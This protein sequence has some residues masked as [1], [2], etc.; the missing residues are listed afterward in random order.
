MRQ[1]E[2]WQCKECMARLCETCPDYNCA[3]PSIATPTSI[4][5]A[6][7]GEERGLSSNELSL[8]LSSPNQLLSPVLRQMLKANILYTTG[9]G[10]GTRYNLLQNS[11][12]EADDPTL[13]VVHHGTLHQDSHPQSID[14]SLEHIPHQSDPYNQNS[15]PQTRTAVDTL[16]VVC[17]EALTRLNS[18][19]TG[20]LLQIPIL[21]DTMRQRPSR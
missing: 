17:C 9:H 11:A 2:Y 4:I 19:S 8:M 16:A 15:E 21:P 3:G 18:D 20:L 5:E 12:P 14:R 7:I 1:N 13:H 6:L 10:Y